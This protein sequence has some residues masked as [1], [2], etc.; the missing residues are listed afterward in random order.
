M[1]IL[2]RVMMVLAIIVSI[3]MT[4]IFWSPPADVLS[5]PQTVPAIASILGT[6]VAWLLP[7][8]VWG[9]AR[10]YAR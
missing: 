9:S 8:M 4:W 1:P 10:P 7:I 6:M 3:A 2:D 5:H